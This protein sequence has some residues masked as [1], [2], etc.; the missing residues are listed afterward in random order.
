MLRSR[1][2]KRL[3][4]SSALHRPSRYSRCNAPRA[5]SFAVPP[6][7]QYFLKAKAQM[8]HIYLHQRNNKRAFAKCY[9]ELVEAYPSVSSYMFLGE[10]YINIQVP[11]WAGAPREKAAS[12]EAARQ[13]YTQSFA[14]QLSI[15]WGGGV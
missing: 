12:R 10:A 11:P 2:S 6:S 14:Y 7:S 3:P 13:C 5:S 4:W 8:A 9:E 1:N 15:S